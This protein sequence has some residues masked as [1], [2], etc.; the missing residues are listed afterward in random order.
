MNVLWAPWRMAYLSAPPSG[1]G[2]LFCS[3]AAGDEDPKAGVL[4]RAG[5]AFLMLNAFPYA[6]GHLMAVTRRHAGSPEDLTEEEHLDVMRVTRRGMAALRTVYRPDGFN[7]GVNIGRA[8]GAGIDGHYHLHIV[9]RWTG[10][11][12]FM[13]VVGSAKVIPESLEETL[14]RLSLHLS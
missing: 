9:P 11:T 6:S 7:L 5:T 12:N 2:C 10:D 1:S 3:V 4:I 13:A 14:R 8:A